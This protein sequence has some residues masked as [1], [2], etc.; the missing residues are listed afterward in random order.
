MP[1]ANACRCASARTEPCAS[2]SAQWS[3]LPGPFPKD[4]RVRQGDVVSHKLLAG[5][6]TVIQ[7]QQQERDRR[8]LEERRLTRRERVHFQD[9][10]QEAW[11]DTAA[12]G[13]TPA[14]PTHVADS[15]VA[16]TLRALAARSA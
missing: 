8:T 6:L 2:T 9:A 10:M 12:Q 4:S 15:L 16:D 1:V 13:V 3:S 5:A 14:T 11:P 7:R